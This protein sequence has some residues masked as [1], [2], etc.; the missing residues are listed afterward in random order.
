[1]YTLFNTDIIKEMSYL[2]PGT[3]VKNHPLLIAKA[4]DQMHFG[5]I[6]A[7]EFEGNGN[8]QMVQCYNIDD[9]HHIN[10]N[11]INCISST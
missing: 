6:M 3:N 7:G 4:I 10:G 8:D 1:M 11:D 2:H 5:V 9:H